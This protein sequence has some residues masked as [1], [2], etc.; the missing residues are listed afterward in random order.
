MLPVHRI[1]A[2]AVSDHH[3]GATHNILLWT[4]TLLCAAIL[5]VSFY[6]L[7]V[8]VDRGETLAHIIT[9]L[10]QLQPHE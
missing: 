10:E 1:L 6:M 7:H 9:L 5:G 3:N 2:D 4:C 8:I